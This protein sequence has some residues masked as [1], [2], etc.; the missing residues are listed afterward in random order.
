MGVKGHASGYRRARSDIL[1]Q[2]TMLVSAV[3]ILSGLATFFLLRSSQQHILDESMD[4]LIETE[5]RDFLSGY[6]Y[7]VELLV[8]RY[9]D[10]FQ[11]LDMEQFVTAGVE[12]EVTEIQK[13]I[14]EDVQEMLE[15]GFFDLE[16]F[17]LILPAST[18]IPETVV[19]ASNDESLVYEWG[20]PGYLESAIDEG[21]TFL[22]REEGIPDLGL[23]GEQLL[24][25]GEVESPLTPGLYYSYVG[26]KP[27]SEEIAAIS[28][29]FNQEKRTASIQIALALGASVLA[30][31]LITFLLLN[32]LI[33]RRITEPVE[34]LSAAAAEMM[35]G[36]LDVDLNVTPGE[37]FAGLKSA[38]R[39]M[40]ES[41][42]VYVARSVGEESNPEEA[43]AISTPVM[44]GSGRSRI[45]YQ[46]TA[47]VVGI[48]IVYG[49]FSFFIVRRSQ[50]RLMDRGKER[51][52]QSE[53]ENYFSSFD[54]ITRLLIPEYIEQLGYIDMNEVASGLMEGRVTKY[55]RTVIEES[56]KLIDQ[57]VFDI[58]KMIVI[59]PPSPLLSEAVVWASSDESLVGAW[60]VPVEILQ[61]LDAGDHYLIKEDGFPGL[62][63][64]GEYLIVINEIENPVSPGL[65][66]ACL[67]M[68]S[69]RGD[70]DS[71]ED[72]YDGER[73]RS[74]LYLGGILVVSLLI[75]ILITFFI[76]NMLIKRQLTRPMEELLEASER[77]MGGDFGVRVDIQEGEELET[78][79]R[80]F[81]E[82]V[83]SIQRYLPDSRTGG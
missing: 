71:I 43:S 4:L 25:I 28:T 39:Q 6:N 50:E 11:S 42:R 69:L 33:R 52:V 70:L 67:G 66:F 46:I 35:K 63:L 58:D 64:T 72:F 74:D 55:Q 57:G 1:I 2:L 47:V 48:M 37:E 19:W 30:I 7:V 59:I 65:D 60:Q 22:F 41:I 62:G 8:P 40:A 44:P 20:V 32:Y 49:L 56:S 80:A 15:A 81:N 78:L 53:A 13:I 21:A 12:G 18:L 3:V 75:M 24:L 82:M 83:E 36:N 38:F 76:L 9:T 34:E 5:A 10:M 45:L 29:Y 54:Y 31:I 73:R 51:I 14:G 26:V 17:M 61:A 77:V 79:K 27:M 16:K 23:E 68:K